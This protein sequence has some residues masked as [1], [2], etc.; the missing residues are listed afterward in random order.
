M[1]N[2]PYAAF[3]SY[4]HVDLD[5]RWAKWLIEKLETYRTPKALV[6]KGVP[7]RIGTLFRDDDEIPASAD[8]SRQIEQALEAS[9]YLI[10]I[11]SPDTPRSQWVRKEIEIFQR[12]GKGDRILVLLVDG[13][14]AG[15]FPPELLH[16]RRET[17]H[18]DGTTEEVWESVEPIASDVRPRDD[19]KQS[20]TKRRA[21]IRIAAALLRCRFDELMQRDQ[22][23]RRTSFL[24]LGALGL[25]SAVLFGIVLVQ[26]VS[27]RRSAS[28]LARDTRLASIAESLGLANAAT[29]FQD[30]HEL[31]TER[32]GDA[33]VIDVA[34]AILGWAKTPTESMGALQGPLLYSDG[35]QVFFKSEN[36]SALRVGASVPVRRIGFD[37]NRLVLIYPDRVVLLDM[38]ASQVL[39]ELGVADGVDLQA[40]TWNGLAFQ[41]PDGTTV[42]AGRHSGISNALLW[43]AFLT[44][45]PRNEEL[46]VVAPVIHAEGSRGLRNMQTIR[47]SSDCRTFGVPDGP[48]GHF[49]FRLE[50]GLQFAGN[51]AAPTSKELDILPDRLDS[52]M[53]KIV[54][55][56]ALES[57]G[58]TFPSRRLGSPL[59]PGLQPSRTG[60]ME[61]DRTGPG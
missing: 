45:S 23:R 52:F 12:L 3:I 60:G 1:S 38:V 49:L 57:Q 56:R 18:P 5:R 34:D 39:D 4:R 22:R 10:V 42:I 17:T 43:D 58:C 31:L 44:Y 14:P 33:T 9:E 11:C 28:L 16:A 7:Q 27:Q 46:S 54:G 59:G 2:Q 30:L 32:P 25:V 55:K 36:G 24:R 6:R 21:L 29:A 47:L 61:S 41:A 35:D 51:G 8:L 15:S 20:V 48:K 53:F 26:L 50:D 13:E 19:E 40:Y 37:D